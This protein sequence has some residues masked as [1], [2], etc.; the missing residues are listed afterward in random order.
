MRHPVTLTALLLL[1]AVALGG[2][3]VSSF[4]RTSRSSE[5]SPYGAQAAIDGDPTTAWIVDPEGKN[6]GQWIQIDTPIGKIDKLSVIVG[7]SKDEAAWDDYARLKSAT[8]E[9]LNLD[10]PTPEVVFSQPLSFE[11]KREPQIVELPDV[12]VGGEFNGGRVRLVVK[13]VYPG[14]DYAYLAL[15]EVLVHLVEFDAVTVNVRTEPPSSADGHGTDQMTDGNAKTFWAAGGEGPTSFD[16]HG[17]RY[18]VSSLGIV[19][20]PTSHGRP[21]TIE[22]TQSNVTRTYTLAD[23][24]GKAQ[25]V[26]LPAIVGYTG[27]GDGPVTVRIVD[28]YPGSSTKAPAIAD[29]K[30]RATVLEMF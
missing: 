4:K 18:S 11:D 3:E 24:P 1:P 15:G 10:G 13:E 29:V 23:Q 20:G 25:Y 17:G 14:V 8:L 19:Q 30:F 9:I 5:S 28:V 2:F 26:A 7:W 12:E 16:L 27:S 22:V 21:K 6:E